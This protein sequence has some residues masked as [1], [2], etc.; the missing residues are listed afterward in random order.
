MGLPDKTNQTKMQGGKPV[1][2]PETKLTNQGGSV[3]YDS[4]NF[5]TMERLN[6][7]FKDDTVIQKRP[8]YGYAQ[9]NHN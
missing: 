6:N 9:I 4:K 8:G 5:V 1:S 2:I 7:Q 3:Q